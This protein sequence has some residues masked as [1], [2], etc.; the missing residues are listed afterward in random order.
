MK[1]ISNK[2]ILGT[3][4][5]ALALAQSQNFAKTLQAC[6]PGLEVELK[7]IVTS[8][9]RIQDRPLDQVGGKGLFLKEIEAAL[10]NQEI[11]FAVHS[12]KDVPA[13]LP[14]GLMIACYPERLSSSDLLITQTGLT[15]AE[16]PPNAKI[17]TT[18]LRRRV[19]LKRLRPD[20]H[21]EI[22]RG[23]I[24]TRLKRLQQGDFDAIVLAKAGLLRLGIDLQNTYELPILAAPGQGSLAIE[25]RAEDEDMKNLLKPLHHLNSAIVNEAERQLMQRLEGDCNVPFG[26]C[27]KIENSEIEMNAF[28]SD[29]EGKTWIAAN[30]SGPLA[31][32]REIADRLGDMMWK[33]GAEALVKQNRQHK[34]IKT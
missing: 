6:H 13:Q 22:L 26:V 2:I 29:N 15:L 10:L 19:Q 24:D 21:F 28:L 33:Q 23:N 9:D 1:S 12:L 34:N 17:G 18:S 20:L 25:I 7:T 30:L 8:G 3:R 32:Y 4:G 14:K 5:S 27:A 31:D 16:L 11:D